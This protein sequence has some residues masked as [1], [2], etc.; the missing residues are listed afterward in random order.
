VLDVLELDPVR[1]PDEDRKGVRRVSHLGDLDAAPL[2]LLEL[3]LAGV[4]QQRD[5]IEERLLSLGRVGANQGDRLVADRE[6]SVPVGRQAKLRESVSGP[7][8]VWN[9]QHHVVDVVLDLC[10]GA[11]DQA[12]TEPLARLE[13]GDAVLAALDLEVRRQLVERARE[14][15]H[16]QH[17]PLEHSGLARS[18]GYEESQLA[19]PRIRADK[20]EVV[21]AFDHMHAEMAAH[22]VGQC[23]AVR[24]PEGHMIESIRLHGRSLDGS[25]SP[26]GGGAG[27]KDLALKGIGP[28][29]TKKLPMLSASI[30]HRWIVET[31]KEPEFLLLL[32]F[33]ASF[34]FIRTSAHMIRAQVKWWPGNVSVGGTHVHHLVWGIITILV[35]GYVAIAIAPGSPLRE[36][37]AV[38]FGIGAGLTL[39]EFALWLNLQD[40]YW[41]EKGRRSIDAVIIAGTLAVLVLTGLRVWLDLAD[42]VAV[43]ARAAVSAGVGVQL[44]LALVNV[45]KR[46]YAT[47]LTGMFVTPVGLVGAVRLAKPNSLWA[48]RYD[49]EKLARAAARF[50]EVV[51]AAPSQPSV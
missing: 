18:L 38:L 32:A 42:E 13:P 21:A 10:A 34:A 49:R 20:R 41:S 39:D 45:A 37:L 28:G 48:R 9:A 33:L 31:G 25:G 5:V 15:A 8:R 16:A 46:K 44:V 40:V 6:A 12:E 50:G 27:T 35:M 22:E 11:L 4:D 36:I 1:A 43:G 7:V 29:R 2:G 23:V 19:A 3:I 47:A 26:F 24:N 14:I 17:D 51:P 30:Y